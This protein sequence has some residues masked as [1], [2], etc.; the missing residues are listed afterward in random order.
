MTT[1]DA[2]TG[3]LTLSPD[4]VAMARQLAEPDG[5]IFFDRHPLS[6]VPDPW[7][8]SGR[9]VTD[10]HP[11]LHGVDPYR[12]LLAYGLAEVAPCEPPYIVRD[13]WTGARLPHPWSVVLTERGRAWV[14]GGCR[15]DIEAPCSGLR[16][17]RAG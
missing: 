16:R 15:L 5:H 17:R 12:Q 13:E 9:E 3:S 8:V 2:R 11:G 10:G 4:A 1:H 6:N 7:R 14:A